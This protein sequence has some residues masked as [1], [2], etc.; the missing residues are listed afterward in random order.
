[1]P[2][3]T[4][5]SAEQRPLNAPP[6]ETTE[7]GELKSPEVA[8][9]PV[10]NEEP[11]KVQSPFKS[12]TSVAK[13]KLAPSVSPLER[14]VENTL[15]EGLE[16]L[17]KELKPAEQVTFKKYGEDTAKKISLLLGQVKI[18][19][20]EILKLVRMWLNS[21]PGIN[22]YFVEQTAKIKADKIIKFRS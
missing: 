9:T 13:L 21:I 2:E 19:V 4:V 10:K 20:S 7:T 8:V 6:L 15:A 22:K 18:K 5:P 12:V 16:S 3:F 17:Y 11:T 1:M 14:Q